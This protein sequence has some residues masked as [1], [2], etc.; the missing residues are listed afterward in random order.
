MKNSTLYSL[1]TAFCVIIF[2]GIIS[3]FIVVIMF[4]DFFVKLLFNG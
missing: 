4:L 1:F 3:G 2:G